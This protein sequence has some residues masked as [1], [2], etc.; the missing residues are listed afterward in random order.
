VVLP[1]YSAPAGDPKLGLR[2]AFMLAGAQT[3]VT[4]LWKVTDWYVK[5]LLLDFYPR[6]LNGEPRSDAL[7]QAQLAL[8]A[9]YAEHPLYWGGFVCLGDPGPLHSSRPKKRK[10]MFRSGRRG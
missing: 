10:G 8:K 1:A 3:V 2:R 4:S 9:R 5:E 7:R 6:L